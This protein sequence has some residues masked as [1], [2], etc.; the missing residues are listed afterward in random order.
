M[1]SGGPPVHLMWSNIFN[2]EKQK[3]RK[4][5]WKRVCELFQTI[6]A[7]GDFDCRVYPCC[8][9]PQFV[10]AAFDNEDYRQGYPERQPC[11]R[12]RMRD[13]PWSWRRSPQVWSW[14]IRDTK[15]RSWARYRA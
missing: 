6:S 11:K 3:V 5:D 10:A 15:V 7:A 12:G 8:L 14:S 13:W 4:I 9:R 1:F 2:P